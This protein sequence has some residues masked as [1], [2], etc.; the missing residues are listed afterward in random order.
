MYG[1]AS[2]FTRGKGADS[3]G[4]GAHGSMVGKGEEPVE[5]LHEPYQQWLAYLLVQVES[6]T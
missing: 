1:I 5:G 6:H 4:P 2:V 3:P